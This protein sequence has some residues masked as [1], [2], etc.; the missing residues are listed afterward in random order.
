[1]GQGFQIQVNN[2][3]PR[4]VVIGTTAHSPDIGGTAFPFTATLAPGGTTGQLYYEVDS[5]PGTIWLDFQVL[6]DSATPGNVEI[7]LDSDSTSEFPGSIYVA[8]YAQ[9]P[10]T[11]SED[12]LVPLLLVNKTGGSPVW[13]LGVVTIVEMVTQLP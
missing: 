2:A 3:T 13:T 5:N 4:S 6:G 1:M 11:F 10:I 9:G 12:K 8:S 7:R